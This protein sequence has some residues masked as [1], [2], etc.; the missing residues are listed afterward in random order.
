MTEEAGH[1]E[2]L[3]TGRGAMHS[4]VAMMTGH[5]TMTCHVDRENREAREAGVAVAEVIMA[6]Q[7]T[8]TTRRVV[9]TQ[10]T[11]SR[12]EVVVVTGAVVNSRD[13]REGEVTVIV[14]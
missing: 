10:A 2:V 9:A 3:T 12:P 7:E 13:N 1:E 6:R 4:H 5:V 11:G 14:I 8:S